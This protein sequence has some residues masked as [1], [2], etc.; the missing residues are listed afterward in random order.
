MSNHDINI[1]GQINI[2][3]TCAKTQKVDA[4]VIDNC[5]LRLGVE[6]MLNG[7][8]S[9]STASGITSS[10]VNNKTGI[11][12]SSTSTA[13]SRGVEYD[14]GDFA[15]VTTA[16]T[17]TINTIYPT[18]SN[19]TR[20]YGAI[21]NGTVFFAGTSSTTDIFSTPP[22]GTLP[23]IIIQSDTLSVKANVNNGSG[24]TAQVIRAIF[25]A[26]M[27]NEIASLPALGFRFLAGRTSQ[28]SGNASEKFG[29]AITMNHDDTLDIQYT[30]RLTV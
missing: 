30:F 9:N 2:K 8:T 13:I 29:G 10:N 24:G 26:G 1:N 23:Q 18:G 16:A 19:T 11:Y 27:N 4:R 6:N 25:A 22:S 5:I 17:N 3:H 28:T 15:S 14:G 7:I 21:A 20:Y 12:L